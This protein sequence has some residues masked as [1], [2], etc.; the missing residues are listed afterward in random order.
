MHKVF[1]SYH[2]A[3]DQ[4]YK[5]VLL[6]WNAL[7]PTFIDCSVDTG[8]ISDSLG[9]QAIR[10]KIRDEYLRE[11]TVT[12]VLAGA[13]T[14]KRKHVD[15]EVYSSM[16]DGSVNKKSGIIVVNLPTTGSYNFHT[17]HSG[18]KQALYP[19]QTNWQRIT[20][21]TDY[22]ARYPYLLARLIDNL[23]KTEALISVVNWSL[24]ESD[25]SKLGWLIDA[26]FDDRSKCEYDFTERM[27][28]TDYG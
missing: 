16:I 24:I 1:I 28:R 4:H 3:N 21:R 5:D 6:H 18:E 10:Q 27:L 19:S 7:F 14:K 2:H 23:Q 15:W 13:E 25:F 8:D 22:E 12:I 20:N 17:S 11:S 26:T 9:A